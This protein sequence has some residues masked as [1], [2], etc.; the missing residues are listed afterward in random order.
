MKLSATLH[1]SFYAL[2]PNN[3]KIPVTISYHWV[4]L[5]LKIFFVCIERVYQLL[6][7]MNIIG[8]TAQ[9]ESVLQL[10]QSKNRPLN[11]REITQ[12][13]IKV[14]PFKDM[15]ASKTDAVKKTMDILLLKHEIHQVN[16]LKN[17]KVKYSL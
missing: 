5:A 11:M 13:R 15:S 3:D 4:K 14:R 9:E 6:H 17:L 10:F 12:N 16:D 7:D 1:G 8:L 2:E